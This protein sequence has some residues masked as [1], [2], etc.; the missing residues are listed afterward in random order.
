MR[1]LDLFV[2]PPKQPGLNGCVERDRPSWRY[3]LCST[4]YLPHRIDILHAFIDA[5]AYR[6]NHYRLHD[7]F[8][9]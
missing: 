4:Y 8:G 6:F 1:C 3:E 2:V 9:G 5:L 7:S